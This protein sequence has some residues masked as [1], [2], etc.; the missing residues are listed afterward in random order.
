MT[1]LE[2]Q[3]AR[4]TLYLSAEAKILSGQQYTIG[5]G[6]TR[7]QLQ[8]ADLAEVRQEIALL[9]ARIAVLSAG[10]SGQRRV[11]TIVS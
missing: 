7:R 6:T 11:R 10:A 4:L 9:T 2:Q 1:E 5:E 8:R 3:Q